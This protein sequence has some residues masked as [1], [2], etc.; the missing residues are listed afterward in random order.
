MHA[1]YLAFLNS[2]RGLVH[3]AQTERA[4]RLE[5][6]LLLGNLAGGLVNS[7]ERKGNGCASSGSAEVL[8]LFFKL[9]AG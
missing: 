9:Q 4:V 5:L 8:A 7:R 6:A 3:G 1:L 2:W